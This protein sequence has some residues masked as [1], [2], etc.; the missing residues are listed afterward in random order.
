MKLL[1]ICIATLA[2][3]FGGAFAQTFEGNVSSFETP[4][5]MRSVTDIDS[6]AG[7]RRDAHFHRTQVASP[8]LGFASTALGTLI[9]AATRRQQQHRCH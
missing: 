4:Y 5:G 9:N 8:G 7:T 2:F 1:K 3:S 6:P